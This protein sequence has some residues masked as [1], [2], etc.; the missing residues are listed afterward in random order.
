MTRP[1][2][3]VLTV[4][5]A[6]LLAACGSGDGSRSTTTATP[7]GTPAQE[8]AAVLDVMDEYMKDVLDGSYAD[9]CELMTEDARNAMMHRAQNARVAQVTCGS[10]LAKFMGA[11]TAAQRTALE[12]ATYTVATLQG[13]QATV[14]S[15]V[16]DASTTP[17]VK[18]G[19][20][21]KITVTR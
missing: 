18:S 7:A 15:S 21:W 13:D 12:G 20:D 16:R 3:A 2:I 10:S 14:R 8:R 6:C 4:A 5:A 1:T 11:L 19:G 9:A 17:L